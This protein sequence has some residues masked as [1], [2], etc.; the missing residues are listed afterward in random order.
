MYGV[1]LIAQAIESDLRGGGIRDLNWLQAMAIDFLA[2]VILLYINWRFPG[3]WTAT[4]S[5]VAI[6]VL[7]LA[8]SYLAFNALAYWFNFTAVL[9]GI[10]IHS[11]WEQSQERRELRREVE[12]LKSQLAAHGH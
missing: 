12:H 4:L 3:G 6:V 1:E 5:L 11:L 8:G 2:S 7:S 9:L 10:W